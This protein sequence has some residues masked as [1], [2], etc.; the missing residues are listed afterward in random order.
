MTLEPPW[1][2][3]LKSADDV[4]YFDV[5]VFAPAPARRHST[6]APTHRPLAA[7]VQGQQET[8]DEQAAGSAPA[9]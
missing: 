9:G 6:P 7:P 3:R 2:P 5:E 8:F 1:H 4:S